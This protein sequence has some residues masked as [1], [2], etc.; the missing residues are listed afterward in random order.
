[1]KYPAPVI[2]ISE[3]PANRENVQTGSDGNTNET[4]L[5]SLNQE[6]SELANVGDRVTHLT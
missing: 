3:T 5:T 2:T 6:E 1:M 4:N